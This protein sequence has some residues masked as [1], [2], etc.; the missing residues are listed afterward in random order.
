[1]MSDNLKLYDKF[2]TVPPEAKKPIAGGRLKGMTD[3]NP[4]WR[5]KTLTKELG[6]VGVG[7]KYEIVS[8]EIIDGADG[9]KAAFVDILLYFKV[10]NKWSEP[11]PGTGGSMFVE[12]ESRGLHVNDE[13]FKMALTD[14]ISVAGKALGLG[15]DVYFEK[16]RTK[17]EGIQNEQQPPQQ[18]QYSSETNDKRKT[19]IAE[20]ELL[21]EAKRVPPE[22]V[23]ARANKETGKNITDI[24]YL[25]SDV[26]A[27]YTKE[28]EGI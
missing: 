23:L 10:E 20:F 1:M 9:A 8:K 27:K 18:K 6:A 16:D 2:K 25:K 4:M 13:C 14:A 26:I 5:I 15:A 11:I 21:L 12:K 28:L 7:W 17:Y 24:K 3:I 19:E 22:Q